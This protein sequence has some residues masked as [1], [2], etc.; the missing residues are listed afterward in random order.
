MPLSLLKNVATSYITKSFLGGGNTVALN[1]YDSATL[2][3]TA[4]VLYIVMLFLGQWI[5]NN[6]LTQY[7]DVPPLESVLHLL[8]L[9]ILGKLIF[10]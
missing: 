1:E 5:W 3:L 6:I 2:M 4:L 9:V 8:G 10:A 7:V